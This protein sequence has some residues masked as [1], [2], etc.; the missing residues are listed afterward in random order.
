MRTQAE[1]DVL[2]QPVQTEASDRATASCLSGSVDLDRM[3]NKSRSG[4]KR[5]HK[6][7]WRGYLSVVSFFFCCFVFFPLWDARQRSESQLP[8]TEATAEQRGPAQ[9][10]PGLVAEYIRGEMVFGQ[11]WTFGFFLRV[12]KESCTTTH[13]EGKQLYLPESWRRLSGNSKPM[14]S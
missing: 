9:E 10:I 13:G 14:V 12:K 7:L 2:V 6:Q 3:L 1:L 5:E 8:A 11:S 4:W